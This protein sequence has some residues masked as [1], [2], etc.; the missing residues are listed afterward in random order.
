[1]RP[2]LLVGISGA[3]MAALLASCTSHPRAAPTTMCGGDQG[4]ARTVAVY[5]A[6]LQGPDTGNARS[7]THL[8]VSVTWTDGFPGDTSVAS[9]TLSAAVQACLE[10]GI[11]GLP[12]ISF[13]S[14]STDPAVPKEG[15]DPMARV[16]GGGMIVT[17]GQ[18]P[19]TGRVVTPAMTVDSGGGDLRGGTFKVA[20]HG[21]QAR[22]LGPTGHAWIA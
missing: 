9:G 2:H 15:R 20:I 21:D 13:V 18:V 5:A 17:F 7:A 4:A 16:A 11:G 19:T 8:Y 14:G 3:M 10:R 6:L 12:P 1:M 22:L